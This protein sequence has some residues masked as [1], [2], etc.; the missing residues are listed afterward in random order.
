METV[1]GQPCCH[2][3]DSCSYKNKH[4]ICVMT[5]VQAYVSS[6][7]SPN[8]GETAKKQANINR[9]GNGKKHWTANKYHKNIKKKYGHIGW[10][11]SKIERQFMDEAS[12]VSKGVFWLPGNPPRHVFFYIYPNDTLT[13]TDLHQ[14]VK[15]VTFGNPPETNSGYATG[16]STSLPAPIIWLTS[17]DGLVDPLYKYKLEIISTPN[18]GS[19]HART[20]ESE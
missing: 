18:Q 5:D 4:I 2:H 13:S 6:I 10:S 12:G 7:A 15:F 11:H 14:P 19:Q 8:R 16:S 1:I 17:V 9:N 3:I 20:T